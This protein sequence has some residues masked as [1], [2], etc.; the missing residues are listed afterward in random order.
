MK[1]KGLRHPSFALTII[2]WTC[3]LCSIKSN[4]PWGKPDSF[5]PSLCS[6]SANHTAYFNKS[7]LLPTALVSE[8][9]PKGSQDGSFNLLSNQSQELAD[10]ALLGWAGIACL[11]SGRVRP[12]RRRLHTTS[13]FKSLS[14]DTW[15]GQEEGV[16]TEAGA[17]VGG[18]DI[19]SQT[20][21]TQKKKMV[22]WPFAKTSRPAVPFR[23]P[24]PP[25]Y[26]VTH[27][28]HT[29]SVKYHWL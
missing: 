16:K 21:L 13:S 4:L 18:W 17:G 7:P 28:T 6:E 9:N 27:W 3:I 23:K 25:S 1:T 10:L 2:H 29:Q 12:G 15:K 24:E 5:R 8:P 19:R 26:V 11:W 14:T 22:T 20:G